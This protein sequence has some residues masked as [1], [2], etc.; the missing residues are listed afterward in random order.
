MLPNTRFAYREWDVWKSPKT[1]TITKWETSLSSW[2][3][4]INLTFILCGKCSS[5]KNRWTAARWTCSV[6]SSF[7]RTKNDSLP[8]LIEPHHHRRLNTCG[9]SC[10]RLPGRAR[11]VLDCHKS[12]HTFI[13]I[14]VDSVRKLA[15]AYL[16]CPGNR[17]G[18]SRAN[19]IRHLNGRGSSALR[20][21]GL[22]EL[23]PNN[24]SAML[25]R[26]YM[27]ICRWGM[28]A[29]KNIT[30]HL[31]T[32]REIYTIRSIF[33]NINVHTIIFVI[34]KSSFFVSQDWLELLQ[35]R[36]SCREW[37]DHR[38]SIIFTK[39]FWMEIVRSWPSLVKSRKKSS[40]WSTS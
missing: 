24:K 4:R 35:I 2:N 36:F 8:V 7:S 13:I 21:Q 16:P 40:R 1:R 14:R 32:V 30:Q 31:S 22:I 25:Y 33:V 38:L 19:L 20:S 34:F 28:Q 6:P 9:R 10:T 29:R 26:C 17:D 12:N 37:F 5:R 39:R 3:W 18:A 23:R 27:N 15:M 11:L